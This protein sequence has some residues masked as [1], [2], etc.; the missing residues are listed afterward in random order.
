MKTE[1]EEKKAF[2]EWC[3]HNF[4]K[5]TYCTACPLISD[6]RGNCFEKWK[7]RLSDEDKD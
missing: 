1:E 5:A 2:D 4:L 7:E 3:K 6:G